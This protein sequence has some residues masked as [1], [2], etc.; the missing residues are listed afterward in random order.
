MTDP[1][2][3]L[4]CDSTIACKAVTHAT[5]NVAACSKVIW[6]GTPKIKSLCARAYSA[7]APCSGYRFPWMV[8]ATR[9]PIFHCVLRFGP[10]ATIVPDRSPP[11][12]APGGEK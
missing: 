11:V 10:S 1:G 8:P 9:S 7:K 6:S 3:G 5:P 4:P 12:M 2:H